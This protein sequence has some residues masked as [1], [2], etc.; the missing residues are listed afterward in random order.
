MMYYG[1][2]YYD[3][4]L[5][6]WISADSVVPHPG[7]PQDLNRFS[8]TR[9]N[10]LVY[11]DPTGH[12][13]DW[14]GSDIASEFPVLPNGPTWTA[15]E[16]ADYYEFIAM[17]GWRHQVA[18]G[19]PPEI[20]TVIAETTPFAFLD[21]GTLGNVTTGFALAGMAGVGSI[22][23]SIS[24]AERTGAVLKGEGYNVSPESWFGKY[25]EIGKG[26]RTSVTDRR[27]ISDVIGEFEGTGDQ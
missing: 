19:T 20:A 12:Y 4:Y 3:S 18:E 16:L 15:E 25:S 2:R 5:G 14:G 6:R 24:L 21:N 7:N 13:L 8:Y 10:P 17:D 22:G 11:T 26:G 27:A 9:N 23:G 1:A